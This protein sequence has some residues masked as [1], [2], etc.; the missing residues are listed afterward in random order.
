MIQRDLRIT[1][2][3]GNRSLKASFGACVFRLKGK[4]LIDDKSNHN[5]VLLSLDSCFQNVSKSWLFPGLTNFPNGMT[6]VLFKL[7]A[8]S[9]IDL[10][11]SIYLLSLIHI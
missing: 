5:R 9:E 7:V 10:K 11:S 4:R 6:I 1:A 3:S 2:K 8:K